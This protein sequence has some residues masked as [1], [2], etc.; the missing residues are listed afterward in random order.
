MCVVIA[1]ALA[2][3]GL[4]HGQIV[5]GTNPLPSFEVASVR[6]WAPPPPPPPGEQIITETVM[7]VYPGTPGGLTTDR[8]RL[9]GPAELLIASAYGLPM[10]SYSRIIGAPDWVNS[11]AERYEVQ[12]KI[13]STQFAAMQKMTPKEQREQVSLMEQSLLAERFKLKVHFEMREIPVYALVVA[14]GGPKLTP[15]KD[16]GVNKVAVVGHGGSEM[17]A[18]A[19]TMEQLARSPF[20]V[21]GGHAV[22]DQTGLKGAYDFRLSWGPDDPSAAGEGAQPPLLTAIQQQLGLKLVLTKAPAEVVV[23]DHIEKPTGN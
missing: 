14:K 13:D 2:G 17:T 1:S 10:A 8:V 5:H 11:E 3:E 7:R 6:P 21:I 15:A 23:I 16:G 20:L 12:A 4:L 18:T 22:V 19:E 9:A